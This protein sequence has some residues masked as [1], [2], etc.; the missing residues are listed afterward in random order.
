MWPPF[1]GLTATYA[2]PQMHTCPEVHFKGTA[3]L[4]SPEAGDTDGP[5]AD[6]IQGEK[7]EHNPPNSAGNTD[8]AECQVLTAGTAA[9]LSGGRA[10]APA[11]RHRE[12]RAARCQPR[13]RS[14][15]K[16]LIRKQ[17]TFSAELTWLPNHHNADKSLN[18]TMVTLGT[19]WT[20][21]T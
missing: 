9:W 20:S 17:S 10:P 8:P 15:F 6:R 3:F 5:L 11:H 16:T 7:A 1:H 4:F 19:I 21:L 13:K 2:G 18:Q 12:C 14:I